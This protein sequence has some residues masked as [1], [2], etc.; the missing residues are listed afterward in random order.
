MEVEHIGRI[1]RPR[2]DL[3]GII[4]GRGAEKE[5]VAGRGPGAEIAMVT[6]T[7][8]ERRRKQ[9]ADRRGMRMADGGNGQEALPTGGRGQVA[10]RTDGSSPVGAKTRRSGGTLAAVTRHLARIIQSKLFSLD[11]CTSSTMTI[12]TRVFFA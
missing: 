11:I 10:R 6:T 4:D 3:E 12:F 9:T 2:I 1:L 5:S 8:S 7:G